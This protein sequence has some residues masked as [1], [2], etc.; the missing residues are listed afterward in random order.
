M[1]KLSAQFGSDQV[2][3]E[4]VLKNRLAVKEAALKRRR[5]KVQSKVKKKKC[6]FIKS[7]AV[8][9]YSTTPPE[10]NPHEDAADDDAE[11]VGEYDTPNLGDGSEP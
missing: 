11:D 4:A 2:Q 8:G 10:F 7:Q 1:A 9:Q 6:N 5:K 3:K